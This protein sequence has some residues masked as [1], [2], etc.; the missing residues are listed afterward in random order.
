[1]P[2]P[3]QTVRSQALI[4]DTVDY[5]AMTTPAQ[6]KIIKIPEYGKITGVD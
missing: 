4:S 2:T 3:D 5:S 1:L 6:I